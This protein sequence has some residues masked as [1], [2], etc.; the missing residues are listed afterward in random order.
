M[1]NREKIKFLIE[2]KAKNYTEEFPKNYK[3]NFVIENVFDNKSECNGVYD[4]DSAPV[5][6]IIDFSKKEERENEKFSLGSFKNANQLVQLLRKE[7][8]IE[9]FLKI[10]DYE[11][12]NSYIK[13][14]TASCVM[15]L[16]IG[17]SLC[18][19]DLLAKYVTI[20][21]IDIVELFKEYFL[22]IMSVNKITQLVFSNQIYNNNYSDSFNLI[23][24]ILD[25]V[26]QTK[27]EI[28]INKN[29]GNNV[30]TWIFTD[31]ITD[32][33]DYCDEFDCD[34]DYCNEC[35]CDECECDY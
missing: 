20:N 29:G 22:S 12:L 16:F 10:D 27:T 13:G 32:Y 5:S 25:E 14:T 35:E 4:M 30:C 1:N 11:I 31:V 34:D 19:V 21:K 8:R 24:Y 33:R 15:G 6:K 18:K 23:N 28:N 7:S 9:V 2:K 17:L 3:H 26:C